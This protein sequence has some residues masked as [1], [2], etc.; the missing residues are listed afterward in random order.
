MRH[1]P[2]GFQQM[3]YSTIP[4]RLDSREE[5]NQD[6]LV[7]CRLFRSLYYVIPWYIADREIDSP[8]GCY[9]LENIRQTTML[10]F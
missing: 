10:E 6:V 4:N 7:K 5:N 2:K 9:S 3:I 8:V 1:V